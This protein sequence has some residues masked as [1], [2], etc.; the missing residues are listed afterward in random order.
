M[1]DYILNWNQKR[2]LKHV[3]FLE[4]QAFYMAGG[5]VLALQLGHRIS[6]D[7]D[8]YTP[9]HFNATILTQN[10]KKVFGKEI[11]EI[12]Q[13]Q[14][15]VYLTIKKTDLSFFRYPYK[16]IRSLVN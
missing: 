8:F 4:R 16:L 12:S 13:A 15:T 7:L 3:A 9:K 5:T 6:K 14:D 2:I 10:F 1:R 11:E